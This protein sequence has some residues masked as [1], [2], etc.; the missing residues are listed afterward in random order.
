MQQQWSTKALANVA[1]VD[2]TVAVE[3]A[4]VAV[5]DVT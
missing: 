3:S 4:I 2:T 1:E 5:A